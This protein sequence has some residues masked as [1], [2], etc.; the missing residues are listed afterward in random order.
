MTTT[1]P[2]TAA[3]HPR[4]VTR[5]EWLAARM[6]LLAK[7]KELTRLGDALAAQR[8]RLPMVRI[9][10]EYTFEGPAGWGGKAT[11]ADLFDG[12]QQLIVYH[13]MFDPD[14]PPPG[15]SGAPWDEGCEGCS[16]LADNLPRHLEHL[17]ARDTSLVL[18][19]RA[20]LV[21]I[22]PFYRRMGW[23]LPWYSSFGSDFNYDFHVT[24]DP[25]RGSTEW[26][27]RSSE[28]LAE[29]GKIPSTS[30]ELPGLSVFLRIGDDV[31]HTYSTF[32]RGLEAAL[33]TYRLLDLTPFGRQE[34]WED[35]PPG[36]PKTP[37]HEWL[38]HHDRYAEQPKSGSCCC[39][40]RACH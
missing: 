25:E 29:G 3:A 5:A 23:T 4:I 11:L 28:Q 18:I 12:R 8:R 21:K 37:A 15:K 10:K 20:P 35:S 26:N 32:G 36:W 38:R 34:E 19:S 2:T 30:G 17:H 33:T 7:E 13:F 39:S 9:D 14:D 1:L 22:E 24:L 31:F 40:E 6:E 16:F 27:Y